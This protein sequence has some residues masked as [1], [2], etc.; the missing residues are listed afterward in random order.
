M[1]ASSNRQRRASAS[2]L[3]PLR[4]RRRSDPFPPSRAASR[5]RTG[6]RGPQYTRRRSLAAPLGS[7]PRRG[8]NLT[9][10]RRQQAAYWH[11]GSA[12]HSSA[13]PGCSSRK[14]PS[15]RTQ[16][17]SLRCGVGCRSEIWFLIPLTPRR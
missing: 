13:Q 1:L 8:P 4:L 10:A 11:A 2:A 15:A 16:S 9:L 17:N 3:T 14:S 12:V 5:P 6:T 7:R